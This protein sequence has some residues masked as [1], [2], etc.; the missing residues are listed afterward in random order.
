MGNLF[1][2][3]YRTLRKRANDPGNQRYWLPA[4]L[5][6]LDNPRGPGKLLPLEARDW[7][8]GPITGEGGT[9][10]QRG[11]VG[12]WW[13]WRT[14]RFGSQPGDPDL[15][16]YEPIACPSEPWP[17][18][19]MPA[20]TV[21]GLDNVWVLPDPA[22]T[23]LATGYRAVI[24]L[25]L[26][27]YDGRGGLPA[28]SPLR[29]QGQYALEQCACAVE[30]RQEGAPPPSACN[31]RIESQEI[32]GV[33]NVTAT[34]TQVFVDVNAEIRLVGTGTARDTQVIVHDLTV[35][36]PRPETLPVLTVDHLT[37]ESIAPW[38]AENVWIPAARQALESPDGRR[39]LVGNLNA[40][41]NEP[42]NRAQ[43]ARMLTRQLHRAFDETLGAAGAG[44]LPSDVGQQAPNPVDQYI[45]DRV[46]LALNDPGSD[47]YL[48]KLIYAAT[49]PQLE[50]YPI[51]RI[52]LGDQE[53]RG[54]RLED[55]Q[56]HDGRFIGGS[57]I[58]A[59][60]EQLVFDQSVID[61]TV[62]LGA[63]VPPPRVTVER[64][65]TRVTLQVPRPPLKLD[66][67]FSMRFAGSA[68]RLGG[69]LAVTIQRARVLGE[70]R[71]LGD[72]LESLRIDIERLHVEADLSDIEIS[73]RIQSA[74][75]EIINLIL[76]RDYIKTQ[77]LRGINREASKK[78]DAL[79]DAAT[80]Y[81]KKTLLAKL[82]D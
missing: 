47:Y 13:E 22:V 74:F 63:L 56:F 2:F 69:G 75:V 51:E 81:I 76:N 29:V 24:T 18:L 31:D 46:R 32:P 41:L 66:G 77:L 79:S 35:R 45:F 34:L 53:F 50:P 82:G 14:S 42:D 26:G 16:D 6:A 68:D 62:V 64:H 71:F 5:A 9:V 17:R 21:F 8:L 37:A 20:V 7:V 28:L 61:G 44:A 30:Q 40:S 49:D 1:M 60:V 39:G 3:I 38:M 59:P 65:G 25:Q 4:R 52:D 67:R 11:F 48:P 19:G 43:I 36:G 10:I 73:V 27:Y 70:V 58:K 23:S 15:R 78:L 12:Q 55:L 72:D 33:G 54:I 57:N 80:S